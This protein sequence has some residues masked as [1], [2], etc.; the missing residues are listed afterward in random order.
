MESADDDDDSEDDNREADDETA[1]GAKAEDSWSGRMSTATRARVR[2]RENFIIVG[3]FV[4]FCR[5]KRIGFSG[6][7]SVVN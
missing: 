7:V 2:G 4:C 1:V 3:E 5:F 6:F